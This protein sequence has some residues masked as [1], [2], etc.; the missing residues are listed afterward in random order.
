MHRNW[1]R[2]KGTGPYS[3]NPDPDPDQYFGIK[4]LIQFSYEYF[5]DKK[6]DFSNHFKGHSAS[7][8]MKF[9]LFSFWGDN[10]GLPGS[11]FSDSI[12]SRSNPDSERL[13]GRS[14]LSNELLLGA[15]VVR[16]GLHQL[17]LV[18]LVPNQYSLIES[19]NALVPNQHSIINQ[20][21]SMRLY[22][23]NTV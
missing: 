4:I 10:F 23:I 13:T 14:D 22:L 18:A 2:W 17:V 9:L 5:F 1:R 6:T 12:K 7:P 20:N 21:Q 15:P 8:N 19:I 16:L 11:A 3:L